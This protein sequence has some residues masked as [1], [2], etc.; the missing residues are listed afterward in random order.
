MKE[1]EDEKDDPLFAGAGLVTGTHLSSCGH[2]MHAECWQ[3]CVCRAYHL[4][5]F[6]RAGMFASTVDDQPN[7][8][9]SPTVHSIC[10][11]ERNLFCYLDRV[12][13][14]IE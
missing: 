1:D 11:S 7:V 13:N 14:V 8:T 12:I 6:G 2:V 3:R 5:N 4:T 10:T 9:Q